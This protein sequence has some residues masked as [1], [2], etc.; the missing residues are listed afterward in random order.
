MT[1]IDKP[2][3]VG[4]VTQRVEYSLRLGEIIS[5]R[6]VSHTFFSITLEDGTKVNIDEAMDATASLMRE[7]DEVSVQI[8]STSAV[9]TVRPV[10]RWTLLSDAH[11]ATI[12]GAK[13][14]RTGQFRDGDGIERKSMLVKLPESAVPA[15]LVE[16]LSLEAEMRARQILPQASTGLSGVVVSFYHYRHFYRDIEEGAQLSTRQVLRLCCTVRLA[17][18]PRFVVVDQ[19]RSIG[20]AI[21]QQGD[22]VAVRIS[23][24]GRVTVAPY[25]TTAMVI[26]NW[27]MRGV[28]RYIHL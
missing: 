9:N 11:P 23:P 8:D 16:P 2:N 24:E 27:F 1:S 17:G 26:R 4:V 7:G 13:V 25:T 22:R 10:T 12:P 18:T 6:R 28:R 3:R 21:I 5:A 14:L 15:V 20:D 19:D